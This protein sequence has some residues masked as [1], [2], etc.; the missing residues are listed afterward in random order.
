MDSYDNW[1]LPRLLNLM[2]G[3]NSTIE[4]RVGAS[5]HYMEA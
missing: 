2:V 1:V 5:D 3:D 4:E